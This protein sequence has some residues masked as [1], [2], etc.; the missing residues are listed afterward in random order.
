MVGSQ[1][2]LHQISELER[3]MDSLCDERDALE[4]TLRSTDLRL[5]LSRR[6]YVRLTMRGLERRLD[7]LRLRRGL[8]CHAYKQ[9]LRDESRRS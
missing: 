1:D 3:E 6:L 7:T 8:A 9:L 2:L 4:L 5:G